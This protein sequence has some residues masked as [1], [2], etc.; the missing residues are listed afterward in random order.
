M[1]S[2]FGFGKKYGVSGN[3][4][5]KCKK[6]IRKCWDSSIGQSRILIRSRLKVQ[7]LLS[8]QRKRKWGYGDNWLTHGLCK[9]EISDHSRI[10]P[11]ISKTKHK[12][13]SYSDYYSWLPSSG[14][15]FDSFHSLKICR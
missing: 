8:V 9:S 2:G 10:A 1:G 12:R 7:V 15:R 14:R 11:Q 3:S 4:I 6:D 5:K 13:V